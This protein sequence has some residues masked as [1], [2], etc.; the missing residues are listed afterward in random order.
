MECHVEL[1]LAHMRALGALVPHADADSGELLDR[2]NREVAR[3]LYRA[4][5]PGAERVDKLEAVIS[6]RERCKV[7]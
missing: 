4:S 2:E 7:S 5:G 1:V 6:Y 3:G